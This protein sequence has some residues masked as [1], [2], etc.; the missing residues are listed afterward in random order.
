MKTTKTKILSALAKVFPDQ[1]PVSCSA[2]NVLT[3]LKNDMV[4]FQVALQVQQS[5]GRQQL[6]IKV[7]S[8][9]KDYITVRK[10]ELVP[11]ML[12]AFSNHDDNYLKTTPGLFPDIL[13]EIGEDGFWVTPDVWN[14]LWVDV[15]IDTSIKTG[16]YNIEIEILDNEGCILS[17][18]KT[19]VEVI[20]NI[21]PDQTLIHTEWFYCDCLANYYNV[22]VFSKDF[23]NITNNYIKNAASRGINMILTPIFTPPLDTQVGGERLTVQLVNIY[24]TEGVYSFNFDKLKRWIDMCVDAGIK[25][26]EMAHLFT[27][28]GA[29][30]APK[31]MVEVNGVYQQRF[32]WDTH[33]TGEDYKKFLDQFLPA[34]TCILKDCSI[35]ECTYFHISDEPNIDNLDTYMAAKEMVKEHLQE[36]V[37]IDALSN[38]EFYEKGIVKKPI[39]ANNHI[40][41]F[42]SHNVPNLWTYYCCSQGVDVS[43]RFMAMPSARNRIIGAQLYKYNIEGFLHWGYNFY[44]SQYSMEPINPYEITD[45]KQAFPSGDAFLVYPGENGKPVDSIRMMVF[46]HALNDMRAMELLESLAGREFVL[47]LLEY[48]INEPLTFSKYPTCDMYLL[49][50]RNRI[51]RE[52]GKRS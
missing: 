20:N 39:P 49:Q 12:P 11:S 16:T 17:E 32:G 47:N 22:K 46:Y 35:A 28:W 37:I 4:S 31:I 38:Y 52:I 21:L 43:N 45:A 13:K 18:Q 2:C 29:T 9:L 44:N 26:F 25:Y 41:P 34:L 15:E 3:V 24:E 10:V 36:F 14:S 6:K 7:T 1:E 51:N 8:P 33:A 23:W 48:E 19:K 27:Q 30:A 50:L 40:E 5:Q 42:L